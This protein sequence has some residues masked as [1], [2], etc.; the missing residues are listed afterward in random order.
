MKKIQL[1]NGIFTTYTALGETIVVKLNNA[2]DLTD[3][4]E[5]SSLCTDQVKEYGVE[6]D[7][8]PTKYKESSIFDV[9]FVEEGPYVPLQING[10]TSYTPI[11]YSMDE[12][13]NE[14][15]HIELTSYNKW[16]QYNDEINILFLRSGQILYDL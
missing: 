7:D 9:N 8:V 3:T 14:C 11:K 1:I 5:H 4:M 16:N 12:K 13:L 6:I 15:R 10:P 2:L